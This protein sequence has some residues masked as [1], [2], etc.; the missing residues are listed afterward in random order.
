MEKNDIEIINKNLGNLTFKNKNVLITGGS[1]FLG[2]WMCETVL[3]Q[4]GQVICID[5]YSSGTENNINNFKN[6]RRFTEIHHD[7]THPLEINST[8]DYVFHMASRASP[9]EFNRFPLEILKSNTLG[10]INALEIAKKFNAVC[11]FTSTSEI[12]GDP[13]ITPTPEIYRGNVNTLGIRGCYDE[14]KRAGEAICMAYLR[15][16][17]LNIR[18]ARIFNTYG[19]RMRGDGFYG[20]VIPRFIDQALNNRPITIFGDG[21]QTRSFCYVTDQI[22]GLIRLALT[23]GLAGEAVNIGYPGEITINELARRIITI[24]GSDSE[25][26][27]QPLPEDDPKRRCPDITKVKQLLHWTPKTDLDTGL[28]KIVQ[29]YRKK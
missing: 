25:L 14:A 27:F 10:T 21:T 9:F 5:N 28:K 19:P 18:I 16:F 1:G 22:E 8:I 20:R 29:I 13:Q 24:T 12:Y 2:S 17:R 26:E 3:A 11:L 4:G 6:N 15:E 23:P 7:I